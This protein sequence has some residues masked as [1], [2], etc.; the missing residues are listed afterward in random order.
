MVGDNA[1]AIAGG[2]L[3]AFCLD[4]SE[5]AVVDGRPSALSELEEVTFKGH[6]TE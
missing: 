1:A 5:V 2:L 3:K 4:K 6:M